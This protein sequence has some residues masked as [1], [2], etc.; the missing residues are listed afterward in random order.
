[1]SDGERIVCSMIFGIHIGISST[2]LL[3]FGSEWRPVGLIVT[4]GILIAAIIMMGLMVWD[5][6]RKAAS[7]D[8]G[9]EAE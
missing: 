3:V 9:E 4:S 2:L 5:S 7:H 1:M 6:G 8:P